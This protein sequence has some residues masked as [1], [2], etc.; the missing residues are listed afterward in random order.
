MIVQTLESRARQREIAQLYL[1]APRN[2]T[3]KLIVLR[4]HLSG[5]DRTGSS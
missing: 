1:I 3:T 5:R 4:R 2:A